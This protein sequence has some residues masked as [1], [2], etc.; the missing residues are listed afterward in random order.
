M[1]TAREAQ[2]GAWAP[3]TSHAIYTVAVW[4]GTPVTDPGRPPSRLLLYKWEYFR[5]M[6]SILRLT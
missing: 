3:G 1:G 6:Y 5:T 2:P 4:E